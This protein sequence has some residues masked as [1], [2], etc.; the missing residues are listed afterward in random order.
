MHSLAGTC[1]DRRALAIALAVGLSSLAGCASDPRYK[2][3]LDWVTWIEAE[4]KRRDDAGFPQYT[5]G[6]N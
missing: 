3:G 6:P 4:K 5:N 1:L 2:E